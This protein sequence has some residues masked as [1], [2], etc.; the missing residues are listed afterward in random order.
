ML[1]RIEIHLIAKIL[2]AIGL[3]CLIIVIH[4]T[5]HSENLILKVPAEFSI[6]DPLTVGSGF[7]H[8]S[9]THMYGNLFGFMLAVPAVLLLQPV[10]VLPTAFLFSCWTGS[11]AHVFWLQFQD[12]PVTQLCGASGG[13]YGLLAVALL[14]TFKL[15]PLC[16]KLCLPTLYSFI[17]LASYLS[18]SS[19]ENISLAAHIGGLFG[20]LVIGFLAELVRLFLKMAFKR[21]RIGY[22]LLHYDSLPRQSNRDDSAWEIITA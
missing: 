9:S 18:T 11:L 22:S 7:C 15:E 1:Q 21:D 12:Q 2:L 3:L 16:Y 4:A 10:W 17:I 8:T 19:D 14:S 5:G 6:L 13:V 20:G